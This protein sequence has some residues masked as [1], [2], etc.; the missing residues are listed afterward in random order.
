MCR[1]VL[2]RSMSSYFVGNISSRA[3]RGVL[4]HW[5]WEI[6][7]KTELNHIHPNLIIDLGLSISVNL[8]SFFNFT[9][10]HWWQVNTW[11]GDG[12]MPSSHCPSHCWSRAHFL[13][14]AWSKPRLC[15]AN[16]RAG[17]FSNL[18][19]IGWAQSELIPRKRQKTGPDLCSH[20]SLWGNNVS[21][22]LVVQILFSP[23][24]LIDH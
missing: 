22:K 18:A 9:R 19:L 4:T 14:L 17:D 13:S 20:T 1:L 21:N 10:P 15:S 7:M 24:C 16:H 12:L 6:W 11:S 23:S 5:H 2:M 3:L 8:H